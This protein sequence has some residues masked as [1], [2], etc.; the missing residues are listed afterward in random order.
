MNNIAAVLNPAGNVMA[1]MPH[2]ERTTQGDAIFSSM[3]DYIS[4]NKK[5]HTGVLSYLPKT[6]IISPFRPGLQTQELLLKLIITDNAARTVQNSLKQLGILVEVSRLIHWQIDTDS[7]DAIEQIKDSGVLYNERK[8]YLVQEKIENTQSV[9]AYLV[10][11]KDDLLGQQKL[12]MLEDHFSISGAKAIHHGI[13]W[14][15]KC[16]Q[17]SI[18]DIKDSILNTHII[19]NPYA[20]EIYE[21]ER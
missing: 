13:L 8:E 12:Q 19:A 21:Y 1:M 10:R 17:G 14:I 16:Q 20:H 7:M 11:S 6:Q 9:L 3:R 2:P 18:Y 15:F 4:K 5:E